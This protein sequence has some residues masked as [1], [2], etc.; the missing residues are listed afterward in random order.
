LAFGYALQVWR[1][2]RSGRRWVTATS[3]TVL[4]VTGIEVLWALSHL[5]L[6]WYQFLT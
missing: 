1:R 5:I 3:L 6:D 4:A 2:K